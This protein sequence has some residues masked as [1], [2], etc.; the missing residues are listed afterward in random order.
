LLGAY[1]FAARALEL[2]F[3]TQTHPV[4]QRTRGCGGPMID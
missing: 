2:A 1:R 3:L 4:V